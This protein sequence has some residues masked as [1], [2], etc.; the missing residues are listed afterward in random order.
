[1]NQPALTPLPNHSKTALAMPNGAP[2]YRCALQL[3]PFSYLL[4]YQKP[5]PYKSE[6]EYNDAIVAACIDTNTQVIGITDHY[7]IKHSF[8]LAK[9]ARDAGILAFCG[10]EAVHV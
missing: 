1:M 9:T 6:E 7:R 4:R 3:N 2:F 5:T 8:G 10:F